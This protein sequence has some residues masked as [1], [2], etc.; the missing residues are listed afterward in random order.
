MN[1]KDGAKV[2]PP[3]I[4]ERGLGWRSGSDAVGG[5]HLTGGDG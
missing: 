2:A 4:A 3:L 5:S 1:A